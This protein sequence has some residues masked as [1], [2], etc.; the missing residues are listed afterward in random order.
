VL[1]HALKHALI[2]ED[3]TYPLCGVFFIYLM[4][5]GFFDKKPR[6]KPYP[7]IKIIIFDNYAKKA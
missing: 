3:A 1:N 4:I 2:N 7:L 5:A 6:K